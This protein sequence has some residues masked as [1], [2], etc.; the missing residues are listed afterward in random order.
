MIKDKMVG[1]TARI[2]QLKNFQ[3][4]GQL[5]NSAIPMGLKPGE[6]YAAP[7]VVEKRSKKEKKTWGKF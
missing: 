4:S 5:T 3:T 2:E 6:K 7:K 1:Y